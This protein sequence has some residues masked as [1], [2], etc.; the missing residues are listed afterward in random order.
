MEFM[1]E[2]VKSF[3][4]L[5]IAM[6]SIED[7]FLKFQL[8]IFQKAMGLPYAGI[9]LDFLLKRLCEGRGLGWLKILISCY[10]IIAN[11][12]AHGALQG[13]ITVNKSKIY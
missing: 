6:D 9:V 1:W 3:T 10:P 2:M 5:G 4:I 13:A 7:L 12:F 11:I 8:K